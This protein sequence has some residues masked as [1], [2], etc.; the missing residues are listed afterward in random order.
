MHEEKSPLPV[1]EMCFWAE[2][3]SSGEGGQLS[4]LL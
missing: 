4:S 1:V 2:N 3:F